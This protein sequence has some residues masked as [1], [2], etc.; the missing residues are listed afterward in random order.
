MKKIIIISSAIMISLALAVGVTIAG[1]DGGARYGMFSVFA[2]CAIAAFAINWLAFIPANLAKTEHFY[3]LTGSL[4]YLT[5]IGIAVWLSGD[6]DFRAAAVA[7]MVIVW[8]VRLGSFLFLRIQRDG[9]DDRFDQ[10]KTDW[11]RFFM[12]WTLQ[13]LWVLLTAACALAIITGGNRVPLGWI[14]MLGMTIWLA[15][16]TIEVIADQQK[17]TFKKD[18]QNAG[19]FISTGLWSWSRHPNYFGEMLLWFGIAVISL[20]ILSGWQWVC[21]I[22][23]LF[24]YMLITH[25]SGVNKLEQKAEARWGADPGYQSYK[26]ATS[27][28]FPRPPRK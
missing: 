5:V 21:L 12:T 28:L 24:V 10:I 4:T 25:V 27:R 13:A 17:S 11:M 7:L 23:P 20:P 9:K 14:G 2:W 6:I 22:S 19:D 16:F 15:G 18:P 1:S 26:A 3:D 8:A